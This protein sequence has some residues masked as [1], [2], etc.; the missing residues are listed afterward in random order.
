MT[1]KNGYLYVYF[2]L[3]FILKCMTFNSTQGTQLDTTPLSKST[4]ITKKF[5][6]QDSITCGFT[7]C[8]RPTAIKKNDNYI[9]NT[10]NTIVSFVIQIILSVLIIASNTIAIVICTSKNYESVRVK[11]NDI[12]LSLAVADLLVGLALPYHSTVFVDQKITQN[13]VACF[14]RVSITLQ[15]VMASVFNLLL[16][17]IDRYVAILHPYIYYKAGSLPRARLFIVL[18]WSYSVFACSIVCYWNYGPR[19]MCSLTEIATAEFFAAF[20]AV[21][22]FIATTVILVLYA[23]IFLVAFKQEQRMISDL[24]FQHNS[25]HKVRDFKYAKVKYRY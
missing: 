5:E 14:L 23:R 16:V 3:S 2:Y 11:V 7:G 25:H 8:I 24:N 10:A 13:S 4:N 17:T 1:T 21:P 15:H 18:V 20:W 6:G 19:Y 12:V 22:F 9:S